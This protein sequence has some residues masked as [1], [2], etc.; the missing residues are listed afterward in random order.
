[1]TIWVNPIGGNNGAWLAGL[2]DNEFD[3]G[4]V[5]GKLPGL[6]GFKPNAGI[7]LDATTC[8]GPYA[9][10]SSTCFSARFS[11]RNLS[12]LGYPKTQMFYEVIPWMDETECRSTWKCDLVYGAGMT[13]FA[14]EP[15]KT[16]AKKGVWANI[17]QE[18]KVNDDGQSNGFI[19]V[20]YDNTMIYD[21]KNLTITK[22]GK[23]TVNGLLFHALFGQG[24]DLS[25]GSPV[26]QYS[27]FADFEIAD[28]C[29]ALSA[30]H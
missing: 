20:W 11:Y 3:F 7:P 4:T 8:T 13:M 14:S 6:Y 10:D 1:M 29:E 26:Q 19:R 27:Y 22:G 28:S 9:Y 30:N 15:A 2:F 24:F 23:V 5:G 16:A 12:G 21:E 25:Q 18:I 17:R